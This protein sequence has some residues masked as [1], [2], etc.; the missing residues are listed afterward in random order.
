MAT[1]GLVTGG[2]LATMAAIAGSIPG[3]GWVIAAVLGVAAAALS[4][5]KLYESM[6][7]Q[8]ENAARSEWALADDFASLGIDDKITALRDSEEKLTVAVA[9][10]TEGAAQQLVATRELREAFEDYR[11]QLRMQ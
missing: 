9:G 2:S 1:G 10:N 7:A 11:E 4:A 6:D 5:W 3:P 8:S